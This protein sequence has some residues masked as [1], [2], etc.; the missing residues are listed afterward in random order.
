MTFFIPPSKTTSI[1]NIAASTAS[2]HK[3]IVIEMPNNVV[4]S[5]LI[6]QI[7]KNGKNLALKYATQTETWTRTYLAQ[8]VKDD[9]S[10][11]IEKADV[12]AKAATATLA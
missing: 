8:S 11:V 6:K 10:R 12:P 1:P 4:N 3:I 5:A 2:L 7:T 9:F